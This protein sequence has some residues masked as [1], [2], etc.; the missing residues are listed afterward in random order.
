MFSEP[1]IF[2]EIARDAV[3]LCLQSLISA[4][5]TLK[6]KLP[7]EST[8]DVYLFLVRHLLILKEMTQNLDLEN[9]STDRPIDLSGVTGTFTPSRGAMRLTSSR[10]A[11]IR[12]WADL[13]VS[14][15]A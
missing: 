8:L 2:D 5:Q 7:S 4:A 11:R 10:N 1:A 15:V 3:N 9:K 14:G 13:L 12:A 6:S